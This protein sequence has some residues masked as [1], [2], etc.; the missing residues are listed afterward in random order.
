VLEVVG[1]HHDVDHQCLVTMSR[2]KYLTCIQHW[3]LPDLELVHDVF[4][5]SDL[6]AFSRIVRVLLL[7]CFFFSF[8]NQI[9][10]SQVKST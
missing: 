7:L 4:C 9:K 2:G 5:S 3:T 6:T 1:L 10:S 8:S